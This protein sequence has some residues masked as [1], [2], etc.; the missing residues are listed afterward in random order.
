MKEFATLRLPLTYE[1]YD[2]HR[3]DKSCR[4]PKF[5]INSRKYFSTYIFSCFLAL[6]ISYNFCLRTY[7]IFFGSGQVMFLL[8][9]DVERTGE[10][11]KFSKQMKNIRK[12]TLTL[13]MATYDIFYG[14]Y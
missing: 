4:I 11:E 2:L 10:N 8:L 13:F 3:L 5:L 7:W 12:G 6:R 14:F 9:I 1:T